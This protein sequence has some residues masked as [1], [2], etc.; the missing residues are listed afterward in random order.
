MRCRRPRSGLQTSI[1][2][3]LE[4]HAGDVE[5]G[6]L[7]RITDVP[8]DM[9]ISSR[10]RVSRVSDSVGSWTSYLYPELMRPASADWTPVTGAGEALL[11]VRGGEIAAG[12]M[13][14]VF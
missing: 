4:A 8:V 14:S 12:A 6:G 1:C 3:S 5:G 13:L 11:G 9:I 10:D 7:F 2:H